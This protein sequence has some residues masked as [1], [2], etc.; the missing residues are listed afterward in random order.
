MI[1]QLTKNKFIVVAK[2]QDPS[3]WRYDT[4]LCEVEWIM[5]EVETSGLFGKSVM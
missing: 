1:N 3:L 4:H 5:A 2:I